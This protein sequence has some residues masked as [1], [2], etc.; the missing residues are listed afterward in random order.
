MPTV[1]GTL[2]S[3][4]LAKSGKGYNLKGDWD[5]GEEWQYV[6]ADAA[7][8]LAG[9]ITRDGVWPDSGKP[10]FRVSGTPHIGIIT[11][12]NGKGNPPTHKIVLNGQKKQDGTTQGA[13]GSWKEN[14]TPPKAP[15]NYDDFP[16]A[17]DDE[18]NSELPF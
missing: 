5:N 6:G 12:F 10:K 15:D 4:S 11:T 18:E 1:N 16:E 7:K 14:T 3:V 17:L 8:A 13:G 9:H 2:K